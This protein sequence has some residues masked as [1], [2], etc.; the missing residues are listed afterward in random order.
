[1]IACRFVIIFLFSTNLFAQGVTT[2]MVGFGC[3]FGATKTK[4]VMIMEEY[5][6]N[7]NYEKIKESLNSTNAAMQFLAVVVLENENINDSTLILYDPEID[8]INQIKKSSIIVPVCSGCTYWD[9]IPLNE[10]LIPS[11]ENHMLQSANFWVKNIIK[12]NQ[13]INGND[14]KGKNRRSSTNR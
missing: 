7:K 2:D 6:K 1:M 9:K 4:S 8:L 10:L 12:Y 14:K 13:S 5:I 3:G 11:K